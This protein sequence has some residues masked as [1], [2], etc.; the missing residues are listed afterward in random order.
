MMK[1]YAILLVFTPIIVY[2]GHHES[3]A[4]AKKI[5]VGIN[6]THWPV[7]TAT[8]IATTKRSVLKIP[9]SPPIL[10]SMLYLL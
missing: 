6:H 7:N 10:F 8:H 3:T 1:A 4:V 9:S 2:K 5:P